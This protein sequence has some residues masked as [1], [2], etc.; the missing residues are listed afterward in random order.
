MGSASNQTTQS[1]YDLSFKILLIGDS[2]V[3]KSSLLLSFI[4]NSVED[5]S[6]TI[7]CRSLFLAILWKFLLLYPLFARLKHT[8]SQLLFLSETMA[9]MSGETL[10]SVL[11][12]SCL[13]LDWS[14]PSHEPLNKVGNQFVA[15]CAGT[16]SVM[17]PKRYVLLDIEG[18]T[19]PILF[20]SSLMFSS[21]L[22]VIML[23]GIWT[24]PMILLKLDIKLLRAQRISRDTVIGCGALAQCGSFCA[25]GCSEEEKDE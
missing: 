5:L 24:E 3:G 10:G 2:A 6:P 1:S 7:T 11:R 22:L 17:E 16:A 13:G 15:A 23:G 4:S 18:T 19:T 9:F 25:P 8:P 14:S 12:I 21:H 20:V